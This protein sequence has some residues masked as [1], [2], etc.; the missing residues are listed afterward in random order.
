MSHTESFFMDDPFF[1]NSHFLWPRHSMPLSTVR[2]D[3]LHCRAQ[4]IQSLRNKIRDSLL[5]E[6]SEDLHRKFFQSLDDQRS[7]MFSRLVNTETEQ[8][9]QRDL[10]L[11]VD[12]RY[13]SPEDVTVTLS[14]RKL[15][16]MAAKRAKSD[17]SSSPN[18]TNHTKDSQTQ[19]FVPAVEIPDQLNPATLTCSLGEDGLLLNESP[20]SKDESSEECT[21][22]VHFRTSLNFPINKDSTN[23]KE[24]GAEKSD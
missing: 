10:S 19:G 3:F 1:S 2:E 7:S 17:A 16:V 22:P 12:T 15:E 9:K 20:E 4:L 24:D 11:S 6:L 18:S 5:N 23:K 13:F 21:I 8:N 14:G